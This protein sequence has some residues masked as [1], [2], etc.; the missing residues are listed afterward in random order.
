MGGLP[1]QVVLEA[2][3]LSHADANLIPLDA[4]FA[5]VQAGL[6]GLEV[7]EQGEVPIYCWV[8]FNVVTSLLADV[9]RGDLGF[10]LLLL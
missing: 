1:V 6:G 3:V 5:V 9:S 2:R 8:L 7:G 10:D 4:V